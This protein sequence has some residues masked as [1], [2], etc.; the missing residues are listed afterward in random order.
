MARKLVSLLAAAGLLAGTGQAFAADDFYKGKQ[1]TLIVT[2]EGSS[3][4]VNY[5]R[6]V[7]QFMPEHI[8]GKPTMIVQ[9]MPGASGLTGA[10]YIYNVA[11]KDGTV[12]A[13][14]NANIPTAPVLQRDE[15][16]FDV[17]KFNW[18]G[19]ISRDP[20]VGFVWHTAPIQTLEDARTTEI[21]AGGQALGSASVDMAV[22][23]KELLGLKVK[24]VAGYKSSG[25][26]KLALEKG[27]IHAILGNLWTSITTEKPDWFS[28][29]KIRVVTQFGLARHPDLQDVPLFL[30]MAKTPEDRQLLEVNLIKQEFAKPYV[31]P[32]G[33]PPERTGMLRRA[34]DATMKDPRFLE[35]AAKQGMPID[36]PMTGEELA[37]M[38]L[39]VSKTS[40][41]VVKRLEDIF[42]NFRAGR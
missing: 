25:E 14:V 13:A 17:N 20:F 26:T 11:P 15:A 22:L 36:R 27:E 5:A 10:G 33:L 2:S 38:T 40:P 21:I 23:S 35:A 6:L 1:I 8:P 12:I 4:Y 39:E 7:A 29:K 32:P 41:A 9:F 37:A 34:F 28:E 30:D 19:N 16:K 3:A 31:A 42:A 24:V 18:L